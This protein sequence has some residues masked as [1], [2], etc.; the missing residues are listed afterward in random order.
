MASLQINRRLIMTPGPVAVD[1]RV[2]QAMSNSILGQFDPEFTDI[3]ND[4]MELIRASF[5]RKTNGHFQ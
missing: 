4:T 3:M 1:P 2:S 5:K